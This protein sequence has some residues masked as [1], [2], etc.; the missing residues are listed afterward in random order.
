GSTRSDIF[1]LGI[2]TYQMLT[3]RLPYGAEVAK[4]RTRS[5]QRK[6]QY[7]SALD[8]TR[9]IPAWIDEV[10]RKA[11]RPDPYK[12]YGE[13]SEFVCELR[14]P[15]RSTL[16]APTTPLMERNPL[17]FWKCLSAILAAA[18]FLLLVLQHGHRF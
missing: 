9:E 18:L 14:H 6:L 8:D 10:L 15:S 7:R 2:V 11:L 4:T 17:L 5:Q 16:T 1:S 12:R 13:L 3:G